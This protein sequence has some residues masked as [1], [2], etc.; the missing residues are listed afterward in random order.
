MRTNRLGF[1]SFVLVSYMP[2]APVLLVLRLAHALHY[3]KGCF[4]THCNRCNIS[5]PKAPQPKTLEAQPIA[6][7]WQPESRRHFAVGCVDG[8]VEIHSTKQAQP[9]ARVW[10]G[11]RARRRP[12]PGAAASRRLRR[13]RGLLLGHE[14]RRQGLE[15]EA[16]ATR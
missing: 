16:A 13:R 2:L 5:M 14:R 10:H 9:L 1:G 15:G 3:T 11:D 8:R 4:L 7:A 6:L 12:S